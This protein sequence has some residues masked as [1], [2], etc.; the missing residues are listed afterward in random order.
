MAS[1]LGST[2]QPLG[3]PPEVNCPVCGVEVAVFNEHWVCVHR[4]GTSTYSYPSDGRRR[5]PGSMLPVP[6]T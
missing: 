6:G 3:P 5:C 2:D 1:A 4:E